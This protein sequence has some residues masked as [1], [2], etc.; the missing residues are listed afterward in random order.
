MTTATASP[1]HADR[2]RLH[3]A[4]RLALDPSAPPGEQQAAMLGVLRIARSRGW[5]LE[6]FLAAIA[7]PAAQLALPFGWHVRLRF[8]KYR[9]ATVGDVA[10]TEPS[11]LTWC[12]ESME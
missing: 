6:Q 9:G 12:V 2:E 4:L 5:S 3:R 1:P 11:Y 10:E 7:P 8:G